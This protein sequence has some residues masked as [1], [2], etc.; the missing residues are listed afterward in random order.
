M[1]SRSAAKTEH[2]P[3]KPWVLYLLEC[4]ARGRTSLYAGITNDMNARLDAHLSGKGAKYTRANPPIRVVATCPFVDRATASS[5]E[6]Y[7]KQM[8]RAHKQEFIEDQQVIANMESDSIH[9][10]PSPGHDHSPRG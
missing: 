1:H 7:L 4:C 3:S 2:G 5:A 6:W 8:P 10:V 9:Q